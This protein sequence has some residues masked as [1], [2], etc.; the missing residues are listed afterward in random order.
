MLTQKQFIRI[1]VP[2]LVNE[3]I[4]INFAVPFKIAHSSKEYLLLSLDSKTGWPEAKFMRAP[5]A[6]KVLEFLERYIADNGIPRRIRTEPGTVFASEKFK[7]FSQK[8]FIQH[9]NCAIQDHRGNGQVER[10]IRT[11]RE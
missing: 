3:E 7:Q 8:F 6:K 5:T 2:E 11:V 4:A 10:L 1:P 9:I